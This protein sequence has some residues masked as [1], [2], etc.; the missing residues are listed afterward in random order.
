MPLGAFGLRVE[1]AHPGFGAGK[2][3]TL[4][5]NNQN[6]AP[7]VVVQKVD[8]AGRRALAI[9]GENR[10]QLRGDDGGCEDRTGTRANDTPL[11]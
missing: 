9:A 1:P 8:H 4:R 10:L 5:G 7:P 3:L 2:V 6:G 11:K